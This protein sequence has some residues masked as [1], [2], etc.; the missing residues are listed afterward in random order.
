MKY[1]NFFYST[2]TQETLSLRAE[3]SAT[4]QSLIKGLSIRYISFAAEIASAKTPRNDNNKK[5]IINS[6]HI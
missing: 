1:R 2:R 4:K 5:C 3:R 6:Y